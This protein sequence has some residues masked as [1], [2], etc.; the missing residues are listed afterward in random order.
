MR[1]SR[2]G[3][4]VLIVFTVFIG[5]NC[6]YYNRIVGRKNLVDGATAYKERK[7]EEAEK[8]FREVV[9]IDPEAKTMEGK[10]AQLFL[11]R[12]LHSEFI[13][14]RR[15]TFEARDFLGNQ[16]LALAQKIWAKSDPV[17]EYLYSQLMP[18][19]LRLYE[20][21][22][23]TNPASSDVEAVNKKNDLLKKFLNFLAAD[24]NKLLGG[25]SIYDPAKFGQV[26]LS[27]S[28][29]QLI[30]QQPTGYYLFRLNRQL[31]ED[32][33]PNEI[34]KKP[35]KAG[36]AIEQYKKVLTVD[37]NDQG[38]FKAVAS[39]L[40]NIDKKDE[41]LQWI[42]DRS[43]NADIKPE[44]RS[45]AYTSLAARQYSCANGISDIDTVKK[46]VKKDGKDVYQF[47][48][49]EKQEDFDKLKS[50]TEEGLK[51]VDQSLA[52]EPAEVKAMKDLDLKSMTVPQINEKEDLLKIFSSAWSYKA[53]LLYQKMRIAEMENNTADKDSFK[54]KGDEGRK[55]F[56]GLNEIEKNMEAEK[57]ARKKA[58]EEKAANKK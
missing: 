11:A 8:L 15:P 10:T 55:I 18:E 30:A 58:E 33:Y 46:T 39:L 54:V 3:I 4:I 16:S 24:L 42:T 17:S 56:T 13:A 40:D 9:K 31:L 43:K 23:S 26:K 28:S 19:T 7:F 34:A 48:R 53:N 38:S 20:E 1:F 49:P 47:T 32:A 50:C 44:F 21:Y 12:T 25:P 52:N 2:L 22:G 5:A 37:A 36:E 57:D 45:E 6:S 51:L 14:N 27:E 41:S 29:N 35:D